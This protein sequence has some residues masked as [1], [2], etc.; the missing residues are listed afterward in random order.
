MSF[1]GIHAFTL[2][3]GFISS[4]SCPDQRGREHHRG[5]GSQGNAGH[6]SAVHLEVSLSYCDSI[7]WRTCA[8]EP[9]SRSTGCPTHCVR[10]PL[11]PTGQVPGLAPS[12]LSARIVR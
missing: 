10:H 7:R 11:P 3:L 8:Y 1:A 6:L 4:T 5:G 12:R 9:T 2:D